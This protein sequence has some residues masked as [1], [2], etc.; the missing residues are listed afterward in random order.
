MAEALILER[1]ITDYEGIEPLVDRVREQVTAYF[2]SNHQ[3][4]TL[5][6]LVVNLEPGRDG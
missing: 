2:D 4:D 3:N 5:F 6:K 1:L